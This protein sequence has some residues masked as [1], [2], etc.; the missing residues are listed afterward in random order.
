M[1][2]I[3]PQEEFEFIYNTLYN[4]YKKHEIFRKEYCS[5]VGI[6]DRTLKRW[7]DSGGKNVAPFDFNKETGRYS[8]K[9]LNVARYLVGKNYFVDFENS[10]TISLI[11]Q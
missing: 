6:S 3:S 2:I 11:D 10:D 1:K 7:I 9:L 5:I 8:W 4:K